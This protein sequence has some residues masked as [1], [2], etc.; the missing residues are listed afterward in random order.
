MQTVHWDP[1]STE[2]E[3]IPYQGPLSNTPHMVQWAHNHVE[4]NLDFSRYNAS[5]LLVDVH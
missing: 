5:G 3:F 2:T 1:K 4:Q